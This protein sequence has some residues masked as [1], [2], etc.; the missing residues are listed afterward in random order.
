MLQKN[1]QMGA[2]SENFNWKLNFQ[3]LINSYPSPD[4]KFINL[5]KITEYVKILRVNI[6]VS[7]VAIQT[8]HVGY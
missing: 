7:T 8:S 6:I 1:H 3:H 5:N 4:W 2:K